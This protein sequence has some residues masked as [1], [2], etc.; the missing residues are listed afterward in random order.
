MGIGT[1][2]RLSET[3]TGKRIV[4]PATG[5][6]AAPSLQLL[7]RRLQNAV[8]ESRRLALQRKECADEMALF[9]RRRARPAAFGRLPAAR[10][11]EACPSSRAPRDEAPLHAAIAAAPVPPELD[12]FYAQARVDCHLAIRVGPG[13][14]LSVMFVSRDTH[15]ADGAA[16]V[17]RI[18]LHPE[19]SDRPENLA[20]QI[21]RAL[22]AQ[23]DP[24]QH[25]PARGECRKILD[26]LLRWAAR[27]QVFCA[28]PAL[29]SA[30]PALPTPPSG[31]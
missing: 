24:L 21:L 2:S 10:M 27:Y 31:S 11:H 16:R 23:G 19:L 4:P 20:R 6:R 28:P 17:T 1:P 7:L 13:A 29:R 26:E 3:S 5:E 8:K 12:V 9:L 18:A 30:A 15:A 14:H 22:F 25:A